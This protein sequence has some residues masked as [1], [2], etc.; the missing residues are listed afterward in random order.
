LQAAAAHRS[1]LRPPA[2]FVAA[3]TDPIVNA[4][5][6]AAGTARPRMPRNKSELRQRFA[7]TALHSGPAALTEAQK[8]ALLDDPLLLSR[9]H[10][11]VW[12]HEQAHA[13]WSDA[14]G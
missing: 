2:N 1:A 9:L 6:C 10:L 14:I 3:V 11:D 5:V 4:L 12:T 8:N 7:Q 13:Q